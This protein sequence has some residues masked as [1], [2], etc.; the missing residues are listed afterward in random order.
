MFISS[1]T[2]IWWAFL[3]GIF[4]HGC[5]TYLMKRKQLKYFPKWRS[6]QDTLLPY[7]ARFT[8][9]LTL[10][11]RTHQP[12]CEGLSYTDDLA[13]NHSNLSGKLSDIP[14]FW[15]LGR[16][17]H[18]LHY[19]LWSKNVDNC[20]AL[21]DFSFLLKV[22][23]WHSREICCCGITPVALVWLIKLKYLL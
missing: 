19:F 4:L 14:H 5:L 12:F 2:S 23:Q 3:R 16:K 8:S 18:N 9:H 11:V 15:A 13:S 17:Q 22:C 20:S 6:V 1:T 21:I 7:C 10:T